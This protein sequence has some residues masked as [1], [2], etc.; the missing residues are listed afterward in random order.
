MGS[1]QGDKSILD[2]IVKMGG[3]IVADGNDIRAL[4]ADTKGIVID[5]SQCPDLVPILAVLGALSE[6]RTEIVNAHRLR[7]KE[8]DRLKAIS[9]E[10]G[11]L[12][13][14]I[15]EKQDG[16][17]IDGRKSLR[18]GRVDSW[19]DHRIAMALAIAAT[20]CEGQVTISNATSVEKSYP[21]FWEHYKALGGRLDERNMG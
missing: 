20:R 19:N 4:P 16:L 9:S 15:M 14:C 6:G 21:D 2:I 10:L 5:A 7:F 13:A 1:M 18:G 3:Q 8:S 11:K 12:G 17:L